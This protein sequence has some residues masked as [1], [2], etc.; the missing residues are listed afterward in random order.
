MGSVLPKQAQPFV[1]EVLDT[2]E[3]LAGML[4]QKDE[5]GIE[6]YVACAGTST[7]VFQ[8]GD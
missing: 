6:K 5:L 7:V 2:T 8:F 4:L 1:I 3:R